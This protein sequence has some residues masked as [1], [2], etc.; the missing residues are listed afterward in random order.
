M[1]TKDNLTEVKLIYIYIYMEM[2][3]DSIRESKYLIKFQNIACEA[4][5]TKS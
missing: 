1:I 2:D 4:S 5:N 3:I